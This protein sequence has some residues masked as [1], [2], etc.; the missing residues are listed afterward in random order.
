MTIAHRPD[1]IDDA[2]DA[3]AVQVWEDVLRSYAAVLDEQRAFLLTAGPDDL[4]DP[5]ALL[6]P[7]F[8]PPVALPPLPAELESWAQS[9]AVETDGLAQ[10]AADV[11]ARLPVPQPPRR[12]PTA[13]TSSSPTL[14]RSL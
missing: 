7:P 6:P 14:D 8:A 12:L 3:W 4:A 5:R 1:L 11:L 9:L 13:G 2:D 10:L